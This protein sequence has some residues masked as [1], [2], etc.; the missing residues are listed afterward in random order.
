[1]SLNNSNKIFEIKALNITPDKFAVKTSN[2]PLNLQWNMITNAYI[3][4]LKGYRSILKPILILKFKT[5]K[6]GVGFLSLPAEKIGTIKMV[7][8][9]K[10]L[11][12]MR[13][14]KISVDGSIDPIFIDVVKKICSNFTWTYIDAPLK[15]FIQND[16]TDFPNLKEESEIIEYCS[17]VEEELEGAKEDVFNDSVKE[18]HTSS[19]PTTE[20]EKFEIGS[21]IDNQ[22]K[23]KNILFGGMGIVYVIDD[24][25]SEKPK[26]Y[27]LKTFKDEFI[28]DSTVCDQF[29]KEAEIWTKLGKHKNIVQA[30]R[31]MLRE[32]QPYLFLEFIDGEELEAIIKRERLP[33]LTAIDY[34]LQLCNGMIY[35]WTLMGLIHRDLKPANCFIN[36]KNI[37]KISD[38]GLGMASLTKEG[39]ND[40]NLGK[41]A[42]VG[43]IP[44]M[45]PE[46]F[47]DSS[48]AST[49]SD[50]YAFGIILCEM[51]TGINPFFDEDPSEIIDRHLNLEPSLFDYAND[52]EDIT[53]EIDCI[54]KKCVAKEREERYKDFEEIYQDLSVLYEELSGAE[55][56]KT[57]NET[58]SEEDYIKRGVSLK[59]LK[60][61]AEAIKV[62]D[63]AIKIN[64]RSP[65]ILHKGQT[66]GLMKNYD[67]AIKV[68]D[69]FIEMHP[70]Y[71]RVWL[72]KGDVLRMAKRYDEALKCIEKAESLTSEHEDLLSIK[73]HLMGDLGK[74]SEAIAICEQSLKI[75][76]QKYEN[77]NLLGD[78]YM[79][80]KKYDFAKDA[81]S[82]ANELNPRFAEAWAGKGYSLF[83]LGFYK[84]AINA[85]KKSISLEASNIDAIIGMARSYIHIGE[86]KQ[87]N[88]CYSRIFE[89]G[90]VPLEVILGKAYILAISGNT[91]DAIEL[92]SRYISR[93]PD[94]LRIKLILSELYMEVSNPIL[95]K[96]LFP[97]IDDESRIEAIFSISSDNELKYLEKLEQE[98]EDTKKV[99][100]DQLLKDLNTF[101][102][103]TCDLE[104]GS[105]IL[106]KIIDQDEKNRLK[107]MTYLC[108]L[109]KLLGHNEYAEKIYSDISSK[110]HKNQLI[111]DI[112]K[113]LF[114]GKKDTGLFYNMEIKKFA[115][116]L[117]GMLIDGIIEYKEGN[118]PKAFTI[119]QSC[120]E[121]YP[122]AKSCIFFASQLLEL[123][124]DTVRASSLSEEFIKACPESFGFYRHKILQDKNK[125]NISRIELWIKKIIG[126]IPYFLEPWIYYINILMEFGHK[127]KA[128]LT[129]LLFLD[130]YIDKVHEH[131]DSLDFLNIKGALNF[132]LGRYEAGKTYHASVLSLDPSNY[133]AILGTAECNMKL[134][135]KSEAKE[136]LKSEVVKDSPMAKYILSKILTDEKDYDEAIKIT[137]TNDNLPTHTISDVLL[138]GRA[139]ALY[140]KGDYPEAEIYIDSLRGLYENLPYLIQYKYLLSKGIPINTYLPHNAEKSTNSHIMNLIANDKY[141]KGNLLD[142]EK[143]FLKIASYDIFDKNSRIKLGLISYK[144][145]NYN[146]AIKYFKQALTLDSI[147]PVLWTFYGATFWSMKYKES[148]EKAFD[149]AMIIPSDSIP[150]LV[151]YSMYLLEKGCIIEA[152]QYAEKA[153]RLDNSQHNAWL[154]RGRI[155]RKYGN[156]EDAL[157]SA[158]S[159]LAKNQ[160]DIRGWLLKGAIQ[161][162]MNET[163]DA[164][165]TFR[166][167]AEMD[168]NNPIVWYNLGVLSLREKKYD[169]AKSNA[170]RALNAKKDFFEALYLYSVCLDHIKRQD[171]SKRFL[172][173]A[174]KCNLE[175]FLRYK[176]IT[177]IKKDIKYPIK[178]I[179]T[180]DDPFF[181][182]ESRTNDFQNIFRM[183]DFSPIICKE[184][185]L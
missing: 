129:A 20:R 146:Q 25:L 80:Q 134:G 164:T 62:F 99:E 97:S 33:I 165:Y 115:K 93:F 179:D 1:M 7:A 96:T 3:F 139:E 130:K 168:K 128:L 166:K 90:K 59:H 118:Y 76:N 53:E 169:L 170:E 176:K 144:N 44:Y 167:A 45:A 137:G 6:I 57:S 48:L 15:N 106:K 73:G 87:A 75:N 183:I 157:T 158:E 17:K 41:A 150:T 156:L 69:G 74:I 149:S 114:A 174:E 46:L 5:D 125:Q 61:Y 31:L 154:A 10:I 123:M 162:E 51:L 124:H 117:D 30:E 171:E 43:T 120:A 142:A 71:W 14:S 131:K 65:A 82:E 34:S 126:T 110:N 11:M 28:F 88:N 12:R 163:Q 161:L 145:K 9:G 4:D 37:L 60:H 67:E 68:L 140:Q 77:W 152:Q 40:D 133:N 70:K 50:I 132:I 143:D 184:N 173:E 107:A 56:K 29:I 151:N 177:E 89:K 98:I 85:F 101:L 141:K 138:I 42:V 64:P 47:M 86:I 135:K 58:F 136:M 185:V 147:N 72:S 54:F 52:N 112:G 26:T 95:V 109:E 108:I 22:Y 23:V 83:Y 119:F 127:Q 84:E 121:K 8:D 2:G 172:Y 92:L 24:M 36:K 94:D 153:L 100:I 55:F 103:Y 66:L 111:N 32:G 182:E 148:A 155:C 38:F 35:A 21:E 159:A 19:S 113:R 160:E 49:Q 102:I 105:K 122:E 18:L 116:T 104:Y 81:Y 91:E 79:Q 39:N 175:K 181:M 180:I 178:S 27:A 78:Y 16:S 13:L 63:D